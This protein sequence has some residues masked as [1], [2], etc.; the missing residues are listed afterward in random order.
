[1]KV[2]AVFTAFSQLTPQH[3]K[4]EG[5]ELWVRVVIKEIKP[6]KREPSPLVHGLDLAQLGLPGENFLNSIPATEEGAR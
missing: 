2:A 4:I 6:T 1:M 5:T 3:Q